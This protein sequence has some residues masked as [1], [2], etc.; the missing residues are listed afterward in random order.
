MDCEQSFVLLIAEIDQ[1]I[2]AEERTLLAQHLSECADCRARAAA[3]RLQDSDLRQAFA[4]RRR[5]V[6]A[7]AG[8]VIAQLPPRP[9]N[10]R[11]RFGWLPMLAA[12]AAGFLVAVGIFRPWEKAPQVAADRDGK[13][14][15]KLA[16]ETL[17]LAVSNG[18][19]EILAPGSGGWQE[20]NAGS[21]VPV[22]SRVRTG[23]AVR[24]EFRTADGS[25]VGLNRS[26]ELLLTAGRSLELTQGQI[27]ASV[28]EAP[29]P[30]QV[31]IPGATVTALGT[32]FDLLCGSAE[33]VLTV[34]RGSTRVDGKMNRVIVEK[35]ERAKL[36]GGRVRE[37]G[38]AEDLLQT[39]LWVNEILILKGPNNKALAARIDDLLAQIGESKTSFLHEE[40]IR[41]LGFH[42]AL[43]L[44]R[45]LQSERYQAA[46]SKRHI[47]AN[48]LADLAQPWSIPDLIKLLHD[49]DGHVR[50]QAARGLQRLTR[51]TLNHPPAEWRDQPPEMVEALYKQWQEW[52]RDHRHLYPAAPGD[53]LRS[54]FP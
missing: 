23:P 19:V 1:E 22:G 26:T 14:S 36:V 8:R 46:T 29:T 54:E 31:A 15:A 34:L 2:Q 9:A 52:W 43:P 18:A 48:I 50:Y 5:A 42:C 47:A 10:V 41:A 3:F 7:L 44:T 53:Q 20:L 24:C 32:E 25:E 30:F 51:E 28:A 33:S 27:L 35:G 6:D 45:F 37:K 40:E 13:L 21:R 17:L 11:D 4:G 39:T 49:K 38:R 12:A 16:T